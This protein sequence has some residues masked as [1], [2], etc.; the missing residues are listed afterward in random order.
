[1][2]NTIPKERVAKLDSLFDAFSVI[3]EGAYVYVCDM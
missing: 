1:M 3:A 2:D